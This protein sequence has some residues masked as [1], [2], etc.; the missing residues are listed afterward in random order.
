M[1]I[2]IQTVSTDAWSM[3]YFRFGRGTKTLIVLPGL[4]VQ[5]VMQSAAAI[6]HDYQIFTADYTVYVFDR[7]CELPNSYP[8]ND[9]A[10]DTYQAM[11]KLGLQQVSLF[12]A[13]QGG[14][15]ALS[16]AAKHPAFV[17]KLIVGSSS[18]SCFASQYQL[19]E[20]WVQLAQK[21]KAEELLLS[22]GAAVY[23]P[24]LFQKLLPILLET[25]KTVTDEDLRR[26][27]ILA[28]GIRAFDLTKELH[29][30]RCP[31]L[32]ISARDDGVFGPD[33][34]VQME[35]SF[36]EYPLFSSFVYDGYGHAAYDTAPDYRARMLRFLMEPSV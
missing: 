26:F 24:E 11:R 17:E 35:Q 15:I 5:S 28:E 6:A 31:V 22:F 8:I 23:P 9:M 12:G 4:S 13:S 14:M 30:I 29:Q 21:R 20:S 36:A 34:A 33:A 10:T 25:A 2:Q 27:S 1:S 19:V 32:A 16:I 3:N 18:P 7:R